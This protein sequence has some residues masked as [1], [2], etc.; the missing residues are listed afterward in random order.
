[1]DP[2]YAE[3][4]GGSG[5]GA[6]G[7]EGGTG[8][9]T[10]DGGA[11]GGTAG[12]GSGG[13]GKA[14]DGGE[15][16]SDDLRSEAEKLA[17]AIV[18]KK[19]KGMPTKEDVAEWKE[20]KISQQTEAERTA[21]LQ[22]EAEDA[23]A[24]A[25]RMQ[26]EAAARIAAATLGITPEYMDDAIALAALRVTDDVPIEAALKLVTEKHPAFVG[27]TS[28]VPATG[29]NPPPE[30]PLAAITHE[31]FIKM[32]YEERVKLKQEHPEIYEKVK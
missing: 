20:W 31:T 9:N 15:P 17:D 19:L 11:A 14:R 25:G 6:A 26:R 5:A 23:I 4:G 28:G 29:G 24:E 32:P 8:A 10:G 2:F 12:D 18:R 21:A 30:D 22:K 16:G 3:D 27:V 13:S 7:G 1:M